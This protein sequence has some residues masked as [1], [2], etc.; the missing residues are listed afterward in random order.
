MALEASTKPPVPKLADFLKL[1]I[2]TFSA[3]EAAKWEMGEWRKNML[4][5]SLSGIESM[6]Y[7]GK[8]AFLCFTGLD[9]LLYSGHKGI[10]K[11]YLWEYFPPIWWQNSQ[12]DYKYKFALWHPVWKV[13]ELLRKPSLAL[14]F[15]SSVIVGSKIW[16]PPE[17]QSP[18]SI[19]RVTCFHKNLLSTWKYRYFYLLD[20][21]AQVW[22]KR[23]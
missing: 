13:R 18:V 5:S 17:D 6:Y 7:F 4:F 21:P 16:T 9:V 23:L 22:A 10:Y 14:L 15:W 19:P 2:P 12:Q 3:A 20:L 8:L 11:L 1:V